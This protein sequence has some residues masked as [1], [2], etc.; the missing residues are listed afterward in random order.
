MALLIFQGS[1]VDFKANFSNTTTTCHDVHGKTEIGFLNG[2]GSE[3]T[4]F[5]Q[6]WTGIALG[7]TTLITVVNAAIFAVRHVFK[8][9]AGRAAESVPRVVATFYHHTAG[10]LGVVADLFAI[11]LL[12]VLLLSNSDSRCSYFD[13]G[14]DAV[15][16]LY[17]TLVLYVTLPAVAVLRLEEGRNVIVYTPDGKLAEK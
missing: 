11:G 10:V 13:H 2:D 5:I 16:F 15:R 12:L 6:W 14:K 1:V 17:I 4:S 7:V 9:Q 3:F 8:T